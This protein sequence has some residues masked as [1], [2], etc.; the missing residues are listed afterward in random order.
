MESRPPFNIKEF[1]DEIE[2]KEQDKINEEFI[3]QGKRPPTIRLTLDEARLAK[4]L[5][6]NQRSG[7]MRNKPC[8]CGSGKK[9]KKCH[10]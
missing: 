5:T 2:A 8:P 6:T 4:S 9:F 1:A 3:K 7:W 10:W